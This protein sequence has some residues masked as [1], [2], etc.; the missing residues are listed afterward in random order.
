MVARPMVDYL[1]SNGF[2]LTVA[3]RTKAKAEALLDGRKNGTAVGWTTNNTAL[4]EK[5]VAGH[6]AVV[7][8]LPPT[9][10]I[11]VAKMCLKH[12]KSLVT[13]SY[14]S[15]EIKDMDPKAKKAGIL[16]LNEM[17]AVPGFDHMTAIRM[18]EQIKQKGGKI[19]EFYSLSGALPAPEE[20]DNPFRHK[21][22]W[23]PQEALMEGN[24][25]A[26][27]LENGQKMEISPENLMKNPL[28]INI[29]E[30]GKMEAYPNRNSLIY[31]NLYNLNEI[32][33]MY[34]GTLRY[35]N[36]CESMD[37]IKSLEMTSHEITDFDSKSY[38]EVVAGKMGVYPGNVKEKVAE[39]LNLGLESP[40][41]IA[42]DWLGFFDK[43]RVKI[44]EG[45]TFELTSTLMQ[46]KMIL[47]QGARDMVIVLHSFLVENQNGK[48]E[49]VKG[50]MVHFGDKRNTAIARNA[51]LPAAIAIK[52]ILDGTLNETGV[53]LPVIPAVSNPVL[54][55]LETLGISMREEWSLPENEI[56]N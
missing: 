31:K 35:P 3:S 34:R 40:A 52:F 33:T 15:Q 30:I 43:M 26:T 47:P 13:T 2:E 55:E 18:I 23:S 12:K 56:I 32:E 44:Q 9:H 8:L 24:N 51:A 42:L 4:L 11:S 36:W 54:K 45:S 19:R 17:G 49:V 46:E 37:A 6:H 28:Q 10:H 7:S 41:I 16:I 22:S 5:L 38:K 29:P 53:L 21:F 48:R 14:E 27:F 1:L 39:K 50:K 20:T 25:G